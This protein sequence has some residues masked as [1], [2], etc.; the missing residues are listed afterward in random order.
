MLGAVEDGRAILGSPV[1]VLLVMPPAVQG[2]LDPSSRD[3]KT[4]K[5]RISQTVCAIQ[6]TVL[7][8][9]TRERWGEFRPGRYVAFGRGGRMTAKGLEA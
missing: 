8:A 4:N 2:Q 6:R 7:P 9:V 3:A 5:G 1:G